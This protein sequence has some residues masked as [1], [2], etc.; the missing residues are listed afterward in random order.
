MSA[1]NGLRASGFV[2]FRIV[3]NQ[4]E[5]LLLQTSYG[6]HHWTPPKGHVDPGESDLET[7]L[8]ETEEETGLTKTDLHIL[9]YFNKTIEYDVRGKPKTA[10]YLLAELIKHNTSV[11]LSDEHQSFKWVPLD[12]ACKL[13]K[14]QSL[15]EV[16][17]ESRAFLHQYHI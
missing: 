2:I 9:A 13:V 11:K 3:C 7:A 4:I 15:Q 14:H 16:L 6:N 8:R 5:Y 12:E 10:V 17:T 1:V